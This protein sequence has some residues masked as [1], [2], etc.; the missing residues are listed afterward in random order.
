MNVNVK[1]ELYSKQTVLVTANE[2]LNDASVCIDCDDHDWIITII[3][4]D[5]S[6]VDVSEFMNSLIE[7]EIRTIINHDTY[8]AREAIYSARW[9]EYSFGGHRC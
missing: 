3:M 9:N 2:Y 6:E 4:H 5:G 1:K 8:A 7:N